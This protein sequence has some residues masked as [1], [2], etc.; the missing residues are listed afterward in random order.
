LYFPRNNKNDG[1]TGYWLAG[2]SA[3]SGDGLTVVYYGTIQ[4]TSQ[5]ENSGY[6]D[7]A[8]RPLVALP[9]DVIATN[10]DGSLKVAQ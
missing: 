2:P 3:Y 6:G 7:F 5:S 9:A 1:C 8:A 4:I 10:S